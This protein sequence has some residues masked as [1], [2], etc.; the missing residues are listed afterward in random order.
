MTRA[1]TWLWGVAAVVASAPPARAQNFPRADSRWVV[2]TRDGAAVRDPGDDAVGERDVLGG[3]GYPAAY[4]ARNATFLFFRLR[5]AGAPMDAAAASLSSAWGAALDTDRDADHFEFLATATELDSA[6]RVV[7]SENSEPGAGDDARDVVETPIVDYPGER[8]MRVDAAPPSVSGVSSYF[9]SWAVRAEELPLDRPIRLFFGSSSSPER[10]DGD[11]FGGDSSSISE[12]LSDSL[13]CS[14]ESCVP[15]AA[16]C[17]EECLICEG[18]TPVCNLDAGACEAC[19]ADEDCL[20]PS[21]PRCD[22]DGA[23]READPNDCEPFTNTFCEP[24]PLSTTGGA[25]ECRAAPGSGRSAASFVALAL[26]LGVL[27][28]RRGRRTTL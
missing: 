25:C 16:A 3:P 9:V 19:D 28:A 10:L 23:C 22:S 27:R 4:V 6:G 15:C 21:A 13:N 7:L 5:V 24:E 17:G 18:T 1:A 20:D 2:V 14:G 8:A 12:I 11:L 26:A